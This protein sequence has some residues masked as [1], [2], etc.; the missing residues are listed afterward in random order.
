MPSASARAPGSAKV[1][2]D[3]D[4]RSA[5]LLNLLAA[6]SSLPTPP[7]YWLMENVPGF[8]DTNSWR[9]M[10]AVLSGLGYHVQEYLLCPSELLGVPNIRLRYYCVA[11]RRD[12]VI[13]RGRSKFGGIAAPTPTVPTSAEGQVEQVFRCLPSQLNSASCSTPHAS[14][15]RL[16]EYLEPADAT[17]DPVAMID[18][19]TL[20]KKSP[21]FRFEIVTHDALLTSCFTKSYSKGFFRTGALLD[22]AMPQSGRGHEPKPEP[23]PEPGQ[24]E[25]AVKRP[26]VGETLATVDEQSCSCP[27]RRF[28]CLRG[29]EQ[30]RRLLPSEI[31]RLLHYPCEFSWPDGV[32]IQDQWRLLGVFFTLSFLPWIF[33]YKTNLPGAKAM[34]CISEWCVA[35][36]STCCCTWFKMRQ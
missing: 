32:S 28:V 33:S 11:I 26:L 19:Q 9:R 27:G 3:G 20:F 36:W 8:C 22:L 31:M 21:T 23:E 1:R 6:L 7:R 15:K 12:D 25:H 4:T 5:A 29:Q 10:H 34:A 18:V 17:L 30:L 14:A 35:Y 16:S 2:D 13:T 24:E